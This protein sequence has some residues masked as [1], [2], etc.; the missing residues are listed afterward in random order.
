MSQAVEES[1]KQLSEC[2][3]QIAQFTND[4]TKKKTNGKRFRNDNTIR[5]G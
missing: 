4:A 2:R 5:G 3:A 1:E